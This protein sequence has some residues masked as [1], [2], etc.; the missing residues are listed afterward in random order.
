MKEVK[1]NYVRP[2][3]TFDTHHHNIYK[4]NMRTY[5]K[6]FFVCKAVRHLLEA[7]NPKFQAIPIGNKEEQDGSNSSPTFGL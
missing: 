6:K 4:V 5:I 1:K 7:Y 3:R 2:G